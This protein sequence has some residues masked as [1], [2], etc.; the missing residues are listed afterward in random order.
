MNSS[1]TILNKTTSPLF[2]L[3]ASFLLSLLYC[4]PVD[5]LFDDKQI[6]GYIGRLIAKGGVPYRD[7]FD[8]KPPL[9]YF[10]NYFGP[11]GLWLIDTFLVGL[12]SL[13]FFRLCQ[14]HRLAWPW[15]LPLLFN[16]LIRNYL[17]CISI[18]M[19]RAYTAVFALLFICILL[20][21]SKYRYFWLGLLTAAT[22]FMQQE[23]VIVLFPFWLY[24][25]PT[26]FLPGRRTLPAGTSPASSLPGRM[27][28]TLLTLAG[29]ITAS[30]PIILYFSLNH[31][32]SWFWQCAFQFNFL[33]YDEKVPF[34]VH[35]R[36]AKDALEYSGLM[37]TFLMAV[38]A[39]FCALVL[40]SDNRRL[41]AI[42]LLAVFLSFT[43][44][45]LSGKLHAGYP[46]Y[47]Y[48]LPLTSTLPILVFAVWAA[49]REE[50]LLGKKSQGF[51]GLLLCCLPL[52]SAFQRGTHLSTHNEDLVKSTPE[53]IWLRQQQLKDY[54]LFSFGSNDWIYVYN[55]FD[56]LAPSRWIYQHFWEHYPRWDAGHR[57]ME[58]IM[59]DL[60]RHHTKYIINDLQH[61]G[62]Q[63]PS[64][65]AL[66]LD[67][68]QKNYQP[69]TPLLWQIK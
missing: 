53:Y 16:L 1:K 17:V 33:W 36:A 2:I 60:L 18:G 37:V 47:Y 31:S 52:Y 10:F 29:V 20:N 5:I 14:K 69:V 64:A 11:W 15:L 50:F 8:H 3:I 63:D 57:Q 58:S 6:F 38:V 12:A 55:Q 13:L 9:I 23:Q 56:I 35:F 44:E 66:W 22:F 27:H 24:A 62:W 21:G 19:T 34:M 42:S 51:Y 25:L 41:I 68:L 28:H 30:A 49:T 61:F 7:V 46:F 67:F 59:N 43:S 45:Y 54:E 26:D 32:L 48:L 4:P 39:G 40:K 65:R